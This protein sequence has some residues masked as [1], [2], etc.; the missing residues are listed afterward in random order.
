[1]VTAELRGGKFGA[2]TIL[3]WCDW[4]RRK[5]QCCRTLDKC[6]VPER[7]SLAVTPRDQQ[8]YHSW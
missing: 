8:C 2:V 7:A 3:L 1:M 6:R 4:Y 5:V